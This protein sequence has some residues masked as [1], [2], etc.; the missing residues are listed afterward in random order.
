MFAT[1][2][3]NMDTDYRLKLH[4]VVYTVNTVWIARTRICSG[5]KAE[6]VGKTFR[7]AT[8]RLMPRVIKSIAGLYNEG[9]VRQLPTEIELLFPRTL[10][11]PRNH[12]SFNGGNDLRAP[13]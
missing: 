1:V 4:I 9:K 8:S 13:Q 6:A 3:C 2:V 5:L 7:A 12:I 10:R 11:I